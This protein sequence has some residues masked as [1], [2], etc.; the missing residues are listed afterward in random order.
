MPPRQWRFRVNDM[1]D[2]IEAIATYS[3]DLDEDG[4]THNRL[5]VD[6][7]LR[8]LTV[9]GEAAAS[10]P[11]T[12]RMAAPKIPWTE[13][14]GMRNVVVHGYFGVSLP[15][16]WQTIQADL[17]QLHNHLAQLLREGPAA[18]DAQ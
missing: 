7:V 13:I 18:D 11:E 10:L 14:I 3:E 17:P 8:N 16:V 5:V 4:F 6:A 1:I 2:A 9:I 15:M 12:I